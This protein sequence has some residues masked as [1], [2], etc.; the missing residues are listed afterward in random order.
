[1]A[2]DGGMSPQEFAKEFYSDHPAAGPLVA[3]MWYG[4]PAEA[5]RAKAALKA[6]GLTPLQDIEQELERSKI[7]GRLRRFRDGVK[8]ATLA[9]DRFD[10]GDFTGCTTTG[11]VKLDQRHRGGMSGGRLYLLGAP[12]GG[13]KTTLLQQLVR[14]AS[15]SGPVLFVSPEMTLESLIGREIVRESGFEE[16][17][18]N[19]WSADPAIKARA[20][21]AH[22][23]AAGR[24]L[25][26]DPPIYTLDQPDVTM[27]EIERAAEAIEGLRCVVIDYAQQVAGDGIDD[28]R[29]RYLQVGEVATRGVALAMRLNVPVVVASQVNVIRE[30]TKQRYTFRESAILEH[31]AHAVMVL[32]VQWEESE[33]TGNRRVKEAWVRCTKNRSGACFSLQVNYD[34]QLYRLRDWEPPAPKMYFSDGALWTPSVP[35][36]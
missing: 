34:A 36:D 21:E 27:P 23:I 5:G 12:T 13:G 19:P 24:I 3:Q 7:R 20:Q 31:K 1:M 35:E 22:A 9:L 10:A 30:G 4:S 15:E 14:R 6:L 33:E 29:A 11:L 26:E 28:Q 18:R 25:R 2:V 16:W 8:G 32:D 17:E